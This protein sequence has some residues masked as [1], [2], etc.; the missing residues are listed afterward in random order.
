MRASQVTFSDLAVADILAQAEWYELQVTET[1]AKRWERAVTAAVLQLVKI[2]HAGARCGFKAQGLQQV[3]RWAVNGF[4]SHL[5]FYQVLGKEIHVLRV[6][7]G[8]R[9]LER[10]LSE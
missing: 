5:I 10:L 1:L 3:R 6:L 2:P 9:D 8:A 7:H 4:P